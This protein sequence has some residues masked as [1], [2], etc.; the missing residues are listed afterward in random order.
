MG[1]FGG[2]TQ[3]TT[4]QYADDP[5]RSAIAQ[6]QVN[7]MSQVLPYMSDIMKQLLPVLSGKLATPGVPTDVEKG[8]WQ[9]GKQ[10]IGQQYKDL[11]TSA[12]EALAGKGTLDSGVANKVMQNLQTGEAKAYEG[13]STDIVNKQYEDLWKT[14]QYAMGY[15][16]GGPTS[17]AIP[18]LT[19]IKSTTTQDEGMDWEGLGSMLGVL[20]PGGL[21]GGG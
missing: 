7:Y 19:P 17:M 20:M 6:P 16:S 1:C 21:F 10:R 18:G 3:E 11:A 5:L 9:T 12:S 4:Q 15:G 8:W 2:K 13:L 14:I